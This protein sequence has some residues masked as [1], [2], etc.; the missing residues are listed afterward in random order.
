MGATIK[1]VLREKV[2]NWMEATQVKDNSQSLFNVALTFGFHK[3]LCELLAK[4][5]RISR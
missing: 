1:I 3:P 5:V 2:V 4:D